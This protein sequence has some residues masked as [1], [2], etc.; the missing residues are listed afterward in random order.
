[1]TPEMFLAQMIRHRNVA[2]VAHFHIPALPALHTRREAP[3]ILKKDESL[4]ALETV[5]DLFL[6][7][8]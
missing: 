7:E 4:P 2:V 6:Q 5:G 8:T 1:M 3:T